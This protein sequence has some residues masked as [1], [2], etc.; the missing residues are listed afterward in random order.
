MNILFLS[1]WFPYPPNNGSKIRILNLLRGL[2]RHHSVTLLGFADQP[3]AD[4]E[5]PEIRAVCENVQIIPWKEYDP[6]HWRAVAGLFS[7]TPR[8]LVDTFSPAMAEKI[9]QALS[10]K[11]FDLVIASQLSMAAYFPYF[12]G[13]PVLFEELELALAYED[14]RQNPSRMQRLLRTLTWFKFRFYISRLLKTFRAVTVVSEKERDLVIRNFPDVKKISVIPNGIDMD[15]YAGVALEPKPNTLIFTGS[16]R[17]PVNYE[18]M[19]WFVSEVFPLVLD[20]IPD[21]EL[22]ITGEHLDLPLPSQKN[23]RLTGYVDDVRQWIAT[24][25]VA[26]APLWSGGGTR[27]KI[28]EAM[29]IGVPVVATSKGAEGL[30]AQNGEHLLIADSPEEFAGHI[31]KLLHDRILV[32]R[33]TSNARKF[34]REKFDW[35]VVMPK[36]LHLVEQTATV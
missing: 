5:A 36:F 9:M 18:A 31:T 16:F 10:A 14:P 13:V 30:N 3:D 20:E 8:S 6:Y 4:L 15:E 33:I 19:V 25:T 17:Y 1:R 32:N 24:S 27:L 21:A 35:D 26:L 28:L 29:A 22:I 7:L 11:T 23:I 34:V 2:G 12:E